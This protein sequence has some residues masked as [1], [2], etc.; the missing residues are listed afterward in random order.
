M[1]TQ[2]TIDDELLHQAAQLTGINSQ[3][4]LIMLALKEL[5][6]RRQQKDL[7]Q[8]AG[9]LQFDND[10]DYKAARTMRHDFD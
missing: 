4:E 7:F 8:L 3:R 6:Q 1:N 5:V 2:V 10:F 9:Q